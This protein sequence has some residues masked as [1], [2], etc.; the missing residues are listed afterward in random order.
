MEFEREAQ[1]RD[2]AD[3]LG[4]IE[5]A[6]ASLDDVIGGLDEA[7]LV[8]SGPD[9]GWSVKDHLAHLA[10]WEVGI[11][12]LLQHRPRYAAMQLDEKAYLITDEDGLNAIIYQQNQGRSF[13]AVRAAFGEAQRELLAA[14]GGLNDADLL[15]TYSHYQRDEAGEDSGAP[16]VGWI[17][18]NTYEHYDEHRGWIEALVR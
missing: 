8:A 3:L 10:A 2:K 14:L 11:A 7:Q 16:I 12:A 1:P 6:R 5:R 13:G 4:R 9:G 17:A 15:K 18:G